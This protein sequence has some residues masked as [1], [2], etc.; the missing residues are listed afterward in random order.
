MEIK[1]KFSVNDIIWCIYENKAIRAKITAVS[2]T[3]DTANTV[4][5]YTID[6]DERLYENQVFSTKEELI[7]SL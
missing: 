5:E 4:I 3:V 7:N 1:T 6:R 2:I